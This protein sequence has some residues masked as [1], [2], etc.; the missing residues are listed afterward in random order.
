[1]H[2][3]QE[4]SVCIEQIRLS[5]LFHRGW[6]MV[7]HGC[8]YTVMLFRLCHATTRRASGFAA[9]DRLTRPSAGLT[10]GHLSR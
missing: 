1:M 8:N 6:S 4:A 3:C 9:G 2:T 5:L 10:E 7:F